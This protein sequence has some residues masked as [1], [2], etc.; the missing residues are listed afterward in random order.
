V[1]AGNVNLEG[2]GE[3]YEVAQLIV[4]EDFDTPSKFVNDIALVKVGVIYF[5]SVIIQKYL[6]GFY[7]ANFLQH[8][9]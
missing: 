2:N 9:F 1:Y 6:K 4:H 5:N 7:R 3:I 8:T